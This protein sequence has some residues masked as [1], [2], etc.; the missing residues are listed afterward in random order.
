MIKT[1]GHS[2]V[3]IGMAYVGGIGRIP[4][5]KC[6]FIPVR[7]ACGSI[8]EV[9]SYRVTPF[10]YV[11]GE[12]CIYFGPDHKVPAEFTDTT[13]GVPD[14]QLYGR[15]YYGICGIGKKALYG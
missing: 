12:A 10:R 7:V 6:P 4:I 2:L 3:K 1:V 8:G 11:I 13:L 9:Y 14:H 15:C 5:P